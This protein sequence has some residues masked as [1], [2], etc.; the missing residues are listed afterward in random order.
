VPLFLFFK[1]TNN[2]Y[3]LHESNTYTKHQYVFLKKILHPG[4]IRTHGHLLS[5]HR[6]LQLHHAARAH[7]WKY[8]FN[9]VYNPHTF[10]KGT[11]Y[12]YIVECNNCFLQNEFVIFSGFISFSVFSCAPTVG[13]I[14]LKEVFYLFLLKHL[15]RYIPAYAHTNARICTYIHRHES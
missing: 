5:W 9:Y 10:F 4:E 1:H 7:V 11:T 6:R 14:L 8:F 3:I 13:T 2:T 15:C 12:L